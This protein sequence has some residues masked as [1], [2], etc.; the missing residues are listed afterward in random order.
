MVKQLR[1]HANARSSIRAGVNTL[2]NA[3]KITIGPRGRNVVLDNVLETPRLLNDGVAIA[4]GIDL[5]D[6]FTNMVVH[7]LKEAALETNELVGDGT[8]T[9]MILTQ[10]ILLE[11]FKNIAA[12]SNPMQLRKGIE[13][14]ALAVIEELKTLSKPIKTQ[15]EIAQVAAIATADTASGQLIADVLEHVG[16]DGIALIEEGNALTDEVEY[17]KGM[18]LDR[19]YISPFMATNQETME[20]ILANPY[21]LLTDKKITTFDDLLPLL[22]QLVAQGQK[23]L[24]VIAE[25]ITGEALTTLIVNK[26]HG[27]FTLVALHAPS[28]G[29][30]REAVMQDIAL[31]TG[32]RVITEQAGLRLE[33]ATMNDLG[34]ARSVVVTKNSALIIDGNGDHEA[35]Q[36]RLRELRASLAYTTQA[37]DRAKIQQRMANL[38]GG[39]G[40][41][42]VGAATE[43]ELK[44]RKLRMQD[45][46]AAAHAAIEEGIVPGGGA[47]L[48]FAQS[49]LA[50]VKTTM[51]EET[52][53]IQIL[54]RALEEPCR[55]IVHNAGYEES[56]VI[57]HLREQPFGYGFDVIS[58]HYVDMFKAGIIDPAKVTRI[59]LQT[60]VSVALMLL[61]TDTLVTDAPVFIPD[62]KDIEF[63]L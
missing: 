16:H 34:R 31:M 25:D 27:S 33:Q 44:E 36:T 50:R 53:G 52:V 30:R 49:A 46:L 28:F 63:G 1:F 35:I 13:R 38:A 8:T 10:A 7:M 19:G 45:A 3:V 17:I 18:Q 37:Y 61:T 57:G 32:G 47:A 9:A 12:G 4:R 60:A 48:V 29:E 42:K 51:P 20:A 24:L 55:Q 39:V 56:V 21:I 22:E 41:I 15:K 59:A 54:K 62:F 6:P 23:E 58:G 5:E 40:L 11:G 2:T 14:G 43:V 26:V